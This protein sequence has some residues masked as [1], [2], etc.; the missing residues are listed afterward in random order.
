MYF[1]H[2]RSLISLPPCM[3]VCPIVFALCCFPGGF[4]MCLSLGIG[5]SFLFIVR[6]L[7]MFG[8][9]RLAEFSARSNNYTPPV[10]PLSLRSKEPRV[11]VLLTVLVVALLST[12]FF[13]AV[14]NYSAQ[15]T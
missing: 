14:M 12:F 7:R 15:V 5:V 11:C 3:Y 13:S 6:R 8:E 10:E 1:S 2:F 4:V 9:R